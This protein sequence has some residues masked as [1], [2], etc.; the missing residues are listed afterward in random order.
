MALA[1]TVFFSVS[2]SGLVLAGTKPATYPTPESAYISG[3]NM[4]QTTHSSTY[5][6]NVSYSDNSMVP[7]NGANLP[8]TFTPSYT[9]SGGG[10][11]FSNSSIYT[12]ASSP[13]RYIFQGIYSA[14][15]AS[16]LASHVVTAF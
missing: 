15:N 4:L 10:F 13:G 3:S 14:S 7:F 5:T 8:V 16:V 11:H 1:L 2:G 6:F 12:A 9:P